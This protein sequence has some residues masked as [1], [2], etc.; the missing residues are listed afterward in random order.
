MSWRTKLI[1]ILSAALIAF[2]S[3]RLLIVDGDSGYSP[4]FFDS[5]NMAC[6]WQDVTAASGM[7]DRSIGRPF[8]SSE[9]AILS[10]RGYMIQKQWTVTCSEKQQ[11]NQFIHVPSPAPEVED[12][13]DAGSGNIEARGAAFAAGGYDRKGR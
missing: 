6:S 7:S 1:W 4:V 12:E 3:H 5:G 2:A 10:A 9:E 13:P 8:A 11:N